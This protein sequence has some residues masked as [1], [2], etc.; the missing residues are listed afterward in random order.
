MKNT[1]F[2]FSGYYVRFYHNLPVF[3]K[4][5]NELDLVGVMGKLTDSSLF[6]SSKIA[7]FKRRM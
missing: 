3:I 2:A 1:G 6:Y 4:G 5:K 7:I